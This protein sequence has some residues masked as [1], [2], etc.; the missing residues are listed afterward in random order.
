MPVHD[1]RFSP[2]VFLIVV[3]IFA[4]LSPLDAREEA[5][6]F[7][8]NQDT[9]F[10]YTI[11]KGDTL[12]DLSQ[13]FYNSQWDWPGLWG[14]NQD[15]KNP[16]WIY[17]GNTIRVYLKPE[18]ENQPPEKTKRVAIET[19]FNYPAI[20]KTGFI[21]KE[22]V[23]ALGTV[24]R[25]KE[26]NIMMSTDDIVY[27]RPAGETPLI[28]GH[29]YQIYSISQ[30]D[31]P[32][33]KGRYRGIKHLVKADLEIIEVNSQYAAGKI[34]KAYK[35][36]VSG[37]LVMD[38]Y[39]RA[40]SVEV[41]EYPEPVDAVLLCSE[42]DN[43]MINDYRIAFINKGT[44]DNIRSGN[45]YTIKRGKETESVYDIKTGLDIAPVASGRLI[46]LHTEESSATVM[47]LSS[48]Q[49]IHPGDIVN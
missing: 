12:W 40:P 19:R 44:D 41:D 45:I 13:K 15:I 30:V 47:V 20:H 23:P 1:K 42:D 29:R 36:V 46:V 25:E 32:I 35:D 8:T 26:G 38:F 7:D 37:D 10:Y 31:Q 27:I 17:P 16:H 33:G 6:K 43:V 24:L 11:Q 9:G 5:K 4:S 3:C 34:K 21:K 18:L 14:I 39:T 22:Q 28:T 2:L 48:I 49:D